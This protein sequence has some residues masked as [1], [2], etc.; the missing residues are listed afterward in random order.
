[1]SAP[2]WIRETGGSR[3]ARNLD[4]RTL[5]LFYSMEYFLF[6]FHLK[7][8]L[9]KYI[10]YI[11]CGGGMSNRAKKRLGSIVVLCFTTSLY[12]CVRKGIK[13]KYKVTN[14]VE[15]CILEQLSN[16][17]LIEF[18]VNPKW[19]VSSPFTAWFY[20][21]FQYHYYAVSSPGHCWGQLHIAT[22][23]NT[24]RDRYETYISRPLMTKLFRHNCTIIQCV[25]VGNKKMSFG[26]S[27]L[28]HTKQEWQR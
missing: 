25:D 5:S 23:I 8:Q 2:F 4:L 24:T 27:R 13:K 12:N 3:T 20:W 18:L 15:F 9:G 16:I 21:L 1:M 22:F 26:L 11:N 10:M 28:H 7:H 6:L 19:H 14:N 17:Y